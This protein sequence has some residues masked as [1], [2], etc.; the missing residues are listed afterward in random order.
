LFAGES[1]GEFSLWEANAINYLGDSV[2]QPFKIK[3]SG[4]INGVTTWA[5]KMDDLSR[6]RFE[7][8]RDGGEYYLSLP[9]FRN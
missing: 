2:W 5:S 3:A 4:L 1:R 8:D 9:Q 7:S 6:E